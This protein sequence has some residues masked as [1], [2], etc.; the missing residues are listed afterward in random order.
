MNTKY[1]IITIL[2]PTATGKTKFA[3][4]LCNSVNGE[5]I[6]ADSRQV[7][8]NMNIG[9]GKD[10]EDYIVN[11]VSIP[12]HLIDIVDAGYQYNVFEFQRDFLV[13]YNKIKNNNKTPVLCGGTGLYI[14]AVLKGYKLIDVPVNL[15][16]RKT[17]ENKSLQQL[18]EILK[19]YKTLHNKTDVDTIKRAIRAIEIEEYYKYNNVQEKEYPKIN[20]LI[21]GINCD[22]ELRRKRITARLKNRIS[23]GLI[24][25]VKNLLDS[26]LKPEQLTYYGLEYKF[27]T[28]YII[29]KYS[30]DEFFTKLEIAIHQFAKRQMT[31]FRGMERK[32]TKIYWIDSEVSNDE[33]IKIV[34]NVLQNVS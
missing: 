14:D 10:I 31:Y 11:N 16:L 19:K 26:G 3:A 17:L 27:I 23:E 28:E 29:G 8:R 22:R 13:A 6:S 15:E 24:D 7:Y 34:L 30:F 4:Q 21:I 20:S 1:N 2:G 9:T 12:Y 18:T 33:K 25:E 32:G 5:I